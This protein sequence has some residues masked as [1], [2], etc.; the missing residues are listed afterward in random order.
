VSLIDS[1]GA[2]TA[3]ALGNRHDSQF[4]TNVGIVNLDTASHTWTV[5]V[6]GLLGSKT[7]AVTVPAVSMQQVPLPAGTYGNL[8]LSFQASVSGYWSAYGASVDN[9]SGD[10]WSSHASQP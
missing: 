4:R 9:T 3:Y 5:G 10:S 2:A 6:N 1:V 7:F 8:V